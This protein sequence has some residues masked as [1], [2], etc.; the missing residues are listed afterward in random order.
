[1][2]IAITILAVLL[3]S[4]AFG[5]ET[6]FMIE[7]EMNGTHELENGDFVPMWGFSFQG[8]S[9]MVIPAPLL[10]VNLGDS[11]HIEFTNNAG[12]AHTIHLHGLDVNQAN[13]GV[14]Q[15]SFFVLAGQST[16]YSF[17]ATHTGTYLYHCHVTTTLHLTMGMYGMLVVKHPEQLLYD[18]GP[19]YDNEHHLLT[20]DMDISVN[21]EPLSPGPLNHIDIDYFM[22]NGLSGTQIEDADDEHINVAV[23][24]SLALRIG[25]MAYST[26][27]YTFPAGSNPT[28]YM[29][30]G[31]ELPES[32]Q[33]EVLEV[34]PGERFSVMLDPDSTLS[35]D[36]VVDYYHGVSGEWI[37]Q[38]TIPIE[39]VPSIGINEVAQVNEFSLINSLASDQLMVNVS[40][41]KGSYSIFDVSGAVH[42]KGTW[43]E[44]RSVIDVS[45]LAA[46]MYI[47]SNGE[48][49]VEFVIS[50]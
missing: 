39:I 34:Y 5:Q 31:R 15:T 43:A 28:V 6:V 20:S 4:W 13:D 8:P 10:E 12:E 32:F 33:P 50:R 11:V 46:G 47:L 49:S 44:G 21:M 42:L 18:G 36:L 45:Q 7:S 9:A 37:G 40:E 3:S 25:S 29:S 35:E 2:R 1:M 24:E 38:N 19:H 27:R 14:P 30:D 48:S 41:L 22:V 23:G 26:C 16:T 17:K